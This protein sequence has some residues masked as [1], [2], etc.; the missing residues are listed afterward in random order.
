MGRLTKYD[1]EQI[2][3][4]FRLGLSGREIAKRIA[5]HHSVVERELKRNRSPYFAYEASKADYFSA[6][7]AKK[8]NKRKL[9][10]S[11]KLYEYVLER[12][13]DDWSPEQIAGRLKKHPPPKLKGLT[14]SYEA[15]YQFIYEVEPWLYHKLRY[16]RPV[17]QKHY[18]RK[19]KKV[20]IPEK[21]SIHERPEAVNQRKEIGHFESDTMSCRGKKRALSVQYERAIQ[22]LRIHQVQGFSAPETKEALT[23]TILSMP[24]DFIKSITFDNGGEAA[25]HLEL[26]KEYHLETYFCDTYAAWQ[27]G[28]VE[29][30][31]GLLRQ[32]LPRKLSLENVTDNH[33][34]EIQ[35]R[36]NNHP[37]KNLNYQTPN[38]KLRAYINE[39]AH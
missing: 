1:R 13:A 27:K 39:V 23:Q 38:E 22:L 2:E 12:L 31:N 30:M 32:Y 17:R 33:L 24:D 8:T 9:E 5:R 29:N 25:K 21:V 10:K 34:Q 11:E 3:L 26:K 16:K 7:R 15:I 28:G 14:I 35:E 19:S 18:S 36:L 37:R 4:Y 20:V 6:R